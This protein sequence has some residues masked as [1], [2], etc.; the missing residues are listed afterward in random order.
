MGY[1]HQWKFKQY[2]TTVDNGKAK[3][4]KSVNLLKRCLKKVQVPLG[5]RGGVGEP[6]F[7]D[8]EVIFNGV[9]GNRCETFRI[10][11]E[12][13]DAET[14]WCKTWRN[15][16]DVVVCLALL[17]FKHYFGEDFNYKSDGKQHE[18]EGWELALKIFNETRK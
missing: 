2:P 3:F 8:T 6:T 4:K 7:G 13:Y 12:H 16:Y 5:G 11:Y 1:T 15:N 17:S 14:H 9:G 10:S 18:G